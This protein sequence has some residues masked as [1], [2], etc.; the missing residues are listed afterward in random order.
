[1]HRAGRDGHPFRL[2]AVFQPH[3]YTRTR[4]LLDAFGPALAIADVVVLTDIYA[5]GETPI[6]GI[7]LETLADAV[8]PMVPALHVVRRLED[9]PDEVARMA[10]PGDLVITL[11]AGSISGASQK[12]VAALT[13]AEARR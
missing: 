1:R 13:E 2:I 12:I 5:A 11:G 3:R 7:T 8:R 9:I 4:D 6:P 10:R